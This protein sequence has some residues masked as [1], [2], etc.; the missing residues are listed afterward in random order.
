M[1][2]RHFLALS[3]VL[4]MPVMAYAGAAQKPIMDGQM[5]AFIVSL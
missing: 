1:K 4:L 2:P 5:A 3:L